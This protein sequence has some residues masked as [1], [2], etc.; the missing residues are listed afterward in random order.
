MSQCQLCDYEPCMCGQE[1]Y[2][3]AIKRKRIL[4]EEEINIRY[5]GY[6]SE[7]EVTVKHGRFQKIRVNG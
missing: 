6:V 1:D 4:Q 5:F 3:G 7:K 2:C